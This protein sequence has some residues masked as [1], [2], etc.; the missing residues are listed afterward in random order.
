MG[1]FRVIPL[2]RR[3]RLVT[4]G[5]GGTP[6]P[7]V[8]VDLEVPGL[9]GLVLTAESLTLITLQTGGAGDTIEWN[10]ELILGYDRDHEVATPIPLA[11]PDTDVK[12]ND[13]PRRWPAVTSADE[14]FL[15]HAR[16]RVRVKNK[17]GVTGV[18]TALADATLLIQSPA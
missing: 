12:T 16:L 1:R 5:V 4:S 10:V 9:S 11:G 13:Q 3:L 6:A 7:W 2:F 15:P 18:Q 17:D 14:E 8:Y